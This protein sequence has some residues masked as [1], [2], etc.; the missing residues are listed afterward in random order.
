MVSLIQKV[1]QKSENRTMEAASLQ[2]LIFVTSLLCCTTNQARLTSWRV[3]TRLDLRHRKPYT[4][5][6]D[7]SSL[8]VIVTLSS[9]WFLSCPLCVVTCYIRRVLSSAGVTGSTVTAKEEEEVGECD[10]TYSDINILGHQ[11]QPIRR[12]RENDP[13]YS[14]L[15]TEDASYGQVVFKNTKP[16]NRGVLYKPGTLATSPGTGFSL[17]CSETAVLSITGSNGLSILG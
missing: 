11:Q 8:G 4:P 7:F 16:K 12:S 1:D 2:L 14:A 5:D 3:S 15:R 9:L 13:V 6:L 10:I 17:T